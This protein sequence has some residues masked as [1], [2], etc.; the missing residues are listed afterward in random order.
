MIHAITSTL[1]HLPGWLLV[2]AA[3]VALTAAGFLSER[4]RS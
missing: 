4:G 2:T 1:P 3:C